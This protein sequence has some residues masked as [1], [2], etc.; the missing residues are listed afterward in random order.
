MGGGLTRGGRE[1]AAQ[2]V[3]GPPPRFCKPK[4]TFRPG[5]NFLPGTP[6]VLESSVHTAVKRKSCLRSPGFS[7]ALADAE[8]SIPQLHF[9]PRTGP[10]LFLPGHRRLGLQGS[11][12][13][14][15]PGGASLQPRTKAE[16]QAVMAPPSRDPETLCER[17]APS[18]FL[19]PQQQHGLDASPTFHQQLGTNCRTKLSASPLP[20]T[21]P[22]TS[23]CTNGLFSPSHPHAQQRH[24]LLASPSL[25]NSYR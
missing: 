24:M 13:H 14:R 9:M 23:M 19:T 6:A 2:A 18:V 16:G 22:R 3:P 21:C 11:T 10:H 1:I 4:R 7:I 17:R 8:N 15:P 20:L 12:R 25:S 5:A